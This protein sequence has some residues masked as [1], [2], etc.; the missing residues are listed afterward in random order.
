MKIMS[1]QLI[2]IN[3]PFFKLSPED[4]YYSNSM[5]FESYKLKAEILSRNSGVYIVD[6]I[7][8]FNHMDFD[9]QKSNSEKGNDNILEQIIDFPFEIK[10]IKLTRTFKREFKGQEPEFEKDVFICTFNKSGGF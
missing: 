1:K 6:G 9:H 8:Y 2:Q 5:G 4:Y 10:S 3:D 7:N